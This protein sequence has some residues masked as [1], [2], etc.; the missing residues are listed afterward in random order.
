MSEMKRMATDAER[1]SYDVIV[2]GGGMAGIC[3]AIASAR[4]GAPTAL[5]QDRPVLGGN[6]SS[7]IRMH[8]CGATHHGQ[9]EN[10][11]ETGI[12]EELLLENCSR[13]PQHSFSVF[14]MILWEKV[15][16]EKNLE[17]YLNTRAVEVAAEH[18]KIQY[19][20]AHQLT[21]EKDFRFEGKIYVDCTGDGMI[22]AKAGAVTRQGREGREEFSEKYAPEKA[23]KGTMG[24]SLMFKAVDMGHPVPF[25]KPEWAHE[26]TEADLRFRDHGNHNQHRE[27]VNNYGIESGYWWIELGGTQDTIADAEEIRD[28]LLKVVYGVWDHIKNKGCHGADNYA[29]DWVQFL[30]GKRESRRIEG[31]YILKEQ[32]LLGGYVFED[33]VAYGGWPMDMHPPQGFLF[34]GDPTHYINLKQM[35][36]IPYRCYYS[37][38]IENLMMAGRNISASHMAFGSTRVMG[39]CAVGGQA[40]GTAAAMAVKKQCTPRDIGKT[41]MKELQTRLQKDDCYIPGILCEDTADLVKY[42]KNI[43]CSSETAE[44]S[45]E[46]IRDGHQRNEAGEIHEWISKELSDDPQWLEITF[47]NEKELEQIHIKFDTDLTTE[48]EPT[49]SGAI[50]SKQTPGLPLSLVKEYKVSALCGGVIV[51]DE[52]REENCQ[53]FCM[54]KPDVRADQIKIDIRKTWGGNRAKIFE[55]KAY[56][57]NSV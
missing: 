35:Y 11:R 52:T 25:K 37:K 14:D 46:K 34:S 13:N 48:I 9:R 5:I 31:D 1:K 33:A 43:K 28:E 20:R 18:N 36:T 30:P 16:A 54:H 21:T 17:L 8:I 51:W 22:A 6:A 55:V 29:L 50:R 19:V 56:E 7:E 2:I 42:A 26:Y 32:D 12:L 49:L 41:S 4:N 24:N 47:E 27:N 40:V 23:D 53:R 38:N 15:K 39:T 44:G 57:R 3:A 45:A 10:A